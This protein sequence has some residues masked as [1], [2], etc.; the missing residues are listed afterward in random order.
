LLKASGNKRFYITTKYEVTA[1][2]LVT[3]LFFIWAAINVT[4]SCKICE[5]SGKNI[6]MQYAGLNKKAIYL[7]QL[8]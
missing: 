6:N 3:W 4:S 7:D 8:N 1:G 5:I 2:C